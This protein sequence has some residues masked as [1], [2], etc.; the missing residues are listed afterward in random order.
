MAAKDRLKTKPNNGGQAQAGFNLQMSPPNINLKMPEIKIPE[1]RSDVN[2]D[3][4]P[5]AQALAEEVDGGS[6]TVPELNY[7]ERHNRMSSESG[8][9]NFGVRLVT[10]RMHEDENLDTDLEEIDPPNGESE[11]RQTP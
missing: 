5:V 4:A 2:V 10:V 3:M 8:N 11:Q 1:I 7:F 9:N 6:Y